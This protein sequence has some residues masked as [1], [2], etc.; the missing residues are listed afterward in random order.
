MINRAGLR[1]EMLD[2]LQ[3][4]RELRRFD[5]RQQQLRYGRINAIAAYE[6]AGL[7]GK[8]GVQLRTD[9]NRAQT[10]GH[11]AHRHA[12]ATHPTVHDAL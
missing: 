8:L 2:G 12:T 9:I 4:D 11:V 5:R 1:F 6:L 3:G 7:R 10:I